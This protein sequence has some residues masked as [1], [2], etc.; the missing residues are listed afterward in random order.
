MP[1][2]RTKE[3]RKNGREY[4][5]DV[6]RVEFEQMRHLVIHLTERVAN[7]QRDLDELRKKIRF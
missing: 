1:E 7:L 6:K 2:R 4:R 3:R 5:T